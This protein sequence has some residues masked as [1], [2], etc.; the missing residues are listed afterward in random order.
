MVVEGNEIVYNI[1]HY[2]HIRQEGKLNSMKNL[3]SR[4]DRYY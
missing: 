3:N 1:C 2:I 4:I